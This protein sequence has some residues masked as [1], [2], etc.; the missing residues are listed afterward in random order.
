MLAALILD[1]D[2]AKCNDCQGFL[3]ANESCAAVAVGVHWALPT[4]TTAIFLLDAARV[5][6]RLGRGGN[7]LISVGGIERL[8]DQTLKGEVKRSY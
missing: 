4:G 2:L 5:P 8:M 1:K 7:Y 3:T 6:H